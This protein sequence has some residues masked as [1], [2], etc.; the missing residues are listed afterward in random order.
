MSGSI[1]PS[2]D[3]STYL[4]A[5][6]MIQNVQREDGS[7][8]EPGGSVGMLFRGTMGKAISRQTQEERKRASILLG[9]INVGR[10]SLLS[11]WGKAKTNL[12]FGQMVGS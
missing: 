1:S 10:S 2:C 5:V 6:L 3:F 9:R 8:G 12:T 4:P 11:S 7:C